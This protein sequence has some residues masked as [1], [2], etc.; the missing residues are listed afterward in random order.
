MVTSSDN[1]VASKCGNIHY[2]FN[3]V[4]SVT[5]VVSTA[6]DINKGPVNLL[7]LVKTK[8]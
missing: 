5:L 4:L 6:G 7:R 1:F 8:K 3:F 2:I